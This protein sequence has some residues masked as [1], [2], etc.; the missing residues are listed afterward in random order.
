M[1]R[2]ISDAFE[3][4]LH[5]PER[6]PLILKGA[7]Q[8]GKTFIITEFGKKHFKSFHHFN[9]EENRALHSIFE[10]N[11][12]PKRILDDLGF[13]KQRPI[14]IESD[15]VF[16]DEIQ[17]CPK[18]L[19]ALKYF[20]ENLSEL[21]VIAAGSLLGIQL[22]DESFP[23]GK[24]D[25]LHLHPMNFREF[26]MAKEN[27][28]LLE[29][30]DKAS[31]GNPIPEMAHQG[32]WMELLN[33]YVTGGM[34]QIVRAYMNKKSDRLAAFEEVRH[35]QK[36]LLEGYNKDFAKHSGKTNSVHIV[37]VFENVPT[38]LA[39][40][41]EGST[42]RYRF[43]NVIRGKRGLTQLQ[44]PIDWLEQ[45]GLIMKIHI[46]NR[47]E[48]PL[49]AFCKGSLFK[50][51]LSDIGLLG[52]ILDI[53]VQS[54]LQQDYG[55]TKGYLAE[56]FVAQEFKAGGMDEIYSWTE[57]NSEIEFLIYEG[58]EI[59]PV[60]V[61]SGHRTQAKSLQ[62]FILKYAPPKVYKL[63]AK[64]LSK[65]GTVIHLPLYLAGKLPHFLNRQ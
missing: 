59:V 14:H 58:K 60:E 22:S 50:L 41:M 36:I 38:Q 42:R 37:S 33:Y 28:M 29:A 51:F 17:E 8:V 5:E 43:K 25:F 52:A 44:G 9:F 23:V 45:A 11:Y 57:R 34:P 47:A 54:I 63:S 64:P 27:P 3:K 55:M 65:S 4:W 40:Q 2:F 48:I 32:L 21:A 61:K 31:A 15:L 39:S 20:S 7:R 16:F 13:V 35:L 10:K 6:R 12:D 1:R 62:Q 49:K 56:N 19:T 53:P 46:C 18:A 26:L 30:Y 24:V